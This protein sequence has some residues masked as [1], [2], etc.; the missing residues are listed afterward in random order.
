MA[1]LKTL[2]AFLIYTRD[3]ESN[4]KTFIDAWKDFVKAANNCLKTYTD[5]EDCLLYL[6]SLDNQSKQKDFDAV[7]DFFAEY[8]LFYKHSKH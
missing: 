8:V 3:T 6:E 7:E 1:S 4:S 5:K 2:Q